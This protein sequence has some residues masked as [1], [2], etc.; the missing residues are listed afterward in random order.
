MRKSNLHAATIF[1]TKDYLASLPIKEQLA[2]ANEAREMQITMQKD[3]EN[4]NVSS[5]K[6]VRSKIAQVEA[7]ISK[8]EADRN[9]HLE[10]VD[11]LKK[12]LTLIVKEVTVAQV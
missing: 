3:N 5:D 10:G 4:K 2:Q 1:Q 8:H 9:T 7:K 11:D 6:D 12:E